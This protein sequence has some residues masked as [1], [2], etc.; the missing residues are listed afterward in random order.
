[1][2][3]EAANRRRRA[4]SRGLQQ[5]TQSR[6]QSRRGREPNS[7]TSHAIGLDTILEGEDLA[8]EVANSVLDDPGEETVDFIATGFSREAAATDSSSESEPDSDTSAT[9]PGQGNQASAAADPVPDCDINIF[10]G[11]LKYI[12][13][14][15]KLGHGANSPIALKLANEG[16]T[17]IV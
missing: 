7:P 13:Q 12:L 14:E 4:D 17:S 10:D 2:P 6:R 11:D 9:M 1:M 8:E 15:F 5:E 3:S 16:I